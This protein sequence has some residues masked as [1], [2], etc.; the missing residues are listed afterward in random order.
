LL[1]GFCGYPC[2][3]KW[4]SSRIPPIKR[5]PPSP[6]FIPPRVG[7][8][9]AETT[10]FERIHHAANFGIYN[11]GLIFSFDTLDYKKTAESTTKIVRK[12]YRHS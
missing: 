5:C 6:S 3:G 2:R 4:H 11:Y 8:R 10:I 1:A 7:G 9:G 12:D